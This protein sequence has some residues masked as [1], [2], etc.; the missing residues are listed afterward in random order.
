M[1][2]WWPAASHSSWDPA[3]ESASKYAIMALVRPHVRDC[4]GL[5]S[6]VSGPVMFF[7]KA[8]QQGDRRYLTEVCKGFQQQVILPLVECSG[9]VGWSF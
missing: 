2:G 3:A 5:S 4:R 1:W 8:E 6:F 7:Q 9:S